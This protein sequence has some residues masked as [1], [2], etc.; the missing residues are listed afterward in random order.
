M[1]YGYFNDLNREYVITDPKTPVK[2]INYI[3][4]LDFGGFVDH[5]GG[6]LI[7]KG[8]P[9]INRII[10]YIPQLPASELKGETLYIRIKGKDAYTLFSPFFVPTLDQYQMYECHV[11]LGYTRIISEFYG[12]RTEVVIFVPITGSREIRDIRIT[13]LRAVPVELDVVPVLEYTHF[14][15]QKQLV[16]ADW[17]PQTMQ[18]KCLEE[19]SGFKTL[20]QYAYMH[21]DTRINYFTSNLAAASF[22]TDRKHFLGDN[23]YGTWESPVSLNSRELG[24]HEALRGDNV[25]AM[26]HHLG[27]LE[28]GESRR[29]ITQLGQCSSMIKERHKRASIIPHPPLA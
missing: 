18:S 20:I 15:A 25:A 17:V 12:I 8:D 9:A 29:L 16:N 28:S 2:W 6:A 19:M 21:K 4:N 3:G 27:V 26:M 23:E 13:N 5:T 11:G 1:Q 10:K 14:D 7:C 22:E 24:N